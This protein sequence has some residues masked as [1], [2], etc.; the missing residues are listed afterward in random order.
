VTLIDERGS[1]CGEPD[2]EACVRCIAKNGA[3]VS[4]DS[5]SAYLERYSRLMRGA[6]RVFAPS[7]DTATRYRRRFPMLEVTERPH[8]QGYQF[9][10]PP[11]V[12]YVGDGILRVAII[13]AIG[14]HKGSSFLLECARHAEI[15]QLP[16]RFVV[17]GIT[18]IDALRDH[19]YITIKGAYRDN[20]LAGMLLEHRCH[21][22]L[23]PSLWP[24]TWSYTLSEALDA[25]LYPVAFELGAMAERI[26]S[27]GW[28]TCLPVELMHR[29][30]LVNERLLG[31]RVDAFSEEV[32]KR[33]RTG[34]LHYEPL[35]RD[36]YGL[37][38][39]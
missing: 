21:M 4:V 36:Y 39:R 16:I 8:P 34:D 18:D 11:P 3:P 24:E 37:T 22:A 28:G 7:A 1:Y 14:P 33:I 6:R 27:I 31:L 29:A 38:D 30:D 5:L 2:Q 10:A 13:G 15:H 35:L 9:K 23:F 12:R 26:K 19:P 20:Q 17:F 32:R 25:G